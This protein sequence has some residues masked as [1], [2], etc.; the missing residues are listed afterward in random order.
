M[1]KAIMIQGTMS[2]V[3]KSF[4]T[5]GL[6]RVFRQD[7]FRVAPFKSQNMALNSYVTEDGC[8]MGRAQVMQAEAAGIEPDVCMNPVLL[9]PVTDAGSQVIVNGKPRGNMKAAAYFDYRKTLVPE[10]MEAYGKLDQAYDIIV[11]EGAG[12]PA[13]LNLGRD[14]IVNMGMA[15]LADAPVL[16]VGDI[17][18]GGIFAQ[19][20]GTCALLEP[21]DKER[22]KGLVVNK[23]RGERALFSDGVRILEERSGLPVVGVMPYVSVDIDDEDSLSEKLCQSESSVID[24]AVIKLRRISNFTDF[25]V[26]SRYEGVSVRYVSRKEQLGSPDFIILPGTKSTISDFIWLRESGLEAAIQK[27][28]AEG[29]PLFGICGGYQMLGQK[30]SDPNEVECG[31]EVTGMQMLPADTVFSG[32]K[33][34]SRVSGTIGHVGGDFAALSGVSFTGYEIHMGVTKSEACS[35]SVLSNGVEDGAYRNNVYGSYVHGI[36]D[37]RAV[38]ETIVR[39]LYEKKGLEYRTGAMEMQAYKE[40]QYNRLADAVRENVSMEKIYGILGLDAGVY[41]CI[42]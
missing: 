38:S 26:F 20:L 27:C 22:I 6:C 34:R 16:L 29:T 30:I 10:I 5:A 9:K 31:G 39:A 35:F 25:D 14:D 23:F 7:G 40:L 3:G 21:E 8:E 4:F 42:K 11:I 33:T 2:N 19:L 1:A 12:S 28:V 13:E 37:E 24:I 15:R 41:G 32:K 17:D 36:F 18:R